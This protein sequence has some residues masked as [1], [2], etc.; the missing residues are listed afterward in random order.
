MHE[1]QLPS[2]TLRAAQS[3]KKHKKN[4]QDFNADWSAA[5]EDTF[6][7]DFGGRLLDH[8]CSSSL[9]LFSFAIYKET[10]Q[11]VL[12]VYTIQNKPKST[13]GVR[14]MALNMH[15]ACAA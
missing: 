14:T 9:A 1:E 5:S 6:F 2:F 11:S 4:H 13:R 10:R 8:P 7:F 3:R 12:P 15:A